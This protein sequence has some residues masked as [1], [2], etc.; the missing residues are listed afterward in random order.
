MSGIRGLTHTP[1]LR[2]REPRKLMNIRSNI[3]WKI[4]GLLCTVAIVN[5]FQRVNI[6]VAATSIMQE[7][8]LTQIEMGSVFSAFVLGYTIFQMPG[9]ILADRFGPRKVLGWAT[10]SWALFTVLTGLVGEISAITGVGVL[11]ALIMLRF[12]FGI[13]QAPMFPASGRA[14]ANWFPLKERA[15]GNGVAI[16]GISIGSFLMPPLVSWMVLN[17]SWQRSFFIASIFAVIVAIA[18]SIYARDYPDQHRSVNAAEK[19]YIYEDSSSP[20]NLRASST[21]LKSQL[22]DR[23]LWLLVLSYLLSAYV[24]Y[25][26]I[27]WFYLYLVQVRHFGETESAWLT[28]IPWVLATIT[29]LAGG[30]ISDFLITQIGAGLFLVIGARVD[31]KYIAAGVLAICTGLIMGVEG[32]YWAT[33][34]QISGK[35]TGF[36]GGMLNTGG[37]LGGVISPTLTPWIAQHFGWVNALNFTAL[38]ALCA[39]VLWMVVVPSK[40][41]KELP[42]LTNELCK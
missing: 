22:R 40:G 27:F 23:N 9:G 2:L 3:R 18:W 26:F 37:N 16:A 19:N 28:T 32:P 36:T 12:T 13:C 8:H 1:Y 7:F 34:N 25:V 38:V 42:A 17:L 6:S 29:T 15:R 21:S 11:N 39:A 24:S 4:A 33:A 10:L 20:M 35:N 41:T 30:Y 5:F 31:S 14:V